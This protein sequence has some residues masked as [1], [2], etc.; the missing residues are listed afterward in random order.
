M[1]FSMMPFISSGSISLLVWGL[2]PSSSVPHCIL[3]LWLIPYGTFE[4]V[5]T[6]I[7]FCY[8]LEPVVGACCRHL[9]ILFYFSND[10]LEWFSPKYS[11]FMSKSQFSSP[12]MR[13]FAK[14]KHCDLDIPTLSYL[15]RV[16]TSGSITSSS[17]FY[18]CVSPQ[19]CQMILIMELWWNYMNWDNIGLLL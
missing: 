8:L 11:F 12:K 18:W 2:A 4:G 3:L 7:Y 6:L 13:K 15:S 19:I 10:E 17:I 9:E 14:D 1:V 16:S 5:R